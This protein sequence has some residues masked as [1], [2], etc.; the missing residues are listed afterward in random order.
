MKTRQTIVKELKLNIG[1]F[2]SGQY[3]ADISKI[4]RAAVS[5]NIAKL[6]EEGCEIE[7]V[8]KKGYKLL[9]V[10]EY[11]REEIL[12]SIESNEIGTEVKFYE[13]IGSTNDEAKRLAEL[14]ATNGTVVV[15]ESQVQGKGRLGRSWDNGKGQSVMMS[16]ILRPNDIAPQ[17]IQ[18]I[19]LATAVAVLEGITDVCDVEPRIKW[20][21][22]VLIDGKKICGILAEINCEADRINYL[23]IGI[24]VNVNQEIE[25]FDES[26]RETATSIYLKTGEKL[27][28]KKIIARILF[29]LEQKYSTIV[30]GKTEGIIEDAKKHSATIGKK[31]KLIATDN[32]REA[33]AKDITNRGT[34]VVINEEGETEEIFSGEVSIR[35]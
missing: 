35:E 7:A 18:T 8:T 13:T 28:R 15:A 9:S 12:Y 10:P 5:K 30:C 4:S 25:D 14:G 20:P 31:V 1:E 33:F 26:I 32:V 6:I 22:D 24:G 19:T 23:V 11:S 16:V 2:V 21:N 3:L 27:D 17:N 29:H 34:L